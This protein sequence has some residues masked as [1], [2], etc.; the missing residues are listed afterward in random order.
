MPFAV[1]DALVEGVLMDLI[2]AQVISAVPHNPAIFFAATVT[3]SVVLGYQYQLKYLPS[4]SLR[5]QQLMHHQWLW[6]KSSLISI[7]STLD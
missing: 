5:P 3:V 7:P 4:S 1:D 6:T 2:V